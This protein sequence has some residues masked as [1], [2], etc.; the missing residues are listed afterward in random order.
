M[1]KI[2]GQ[3]FRNI[4]LFALAPQPRPSFAPVSAVQSSALVGTL[5]SR[6]LV[7]RHNGTIRNYQTTRHLAKIL[8]QVHS[9]FRIYAAS[10]TLEPQHFYDPPCLAPH[11]GTRPTI[12]LPATSIQGRRILHTK[13]RLR[14]LFV[15]VLGRITQ[16]IPQLVGPAH[17]GQTI[18]QTHA[19]APP[20][21]LQAL[22]SS[23]EVLEPLLA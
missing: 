23:I 6:H 17:P 5:E 11:C 18:T 14:P 22:N 12:H 19:L 2:F 9:I 8:C 20:P 7:R 4:F 10:S 15:E 21:L 16:G 3:W 1:G 13:I